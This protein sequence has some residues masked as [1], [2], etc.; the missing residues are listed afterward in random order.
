VVRSAE[1]IA[2]AVLLVALAGCA[3]TQ[4]RNARVKLQ[5]ERELA[6]RNPLR[7]GRLNPQVD[8]R[9]VALVRGHGES[10]VIVQLAS[11]SATPLTDVPIAVGVRTAHGRPVQLNG[12]PRLGWFSTHVAAIAPH[13]ET[14]WVFTTRRALPSGVRP[15]ARVGVPGNGPH[16]DVAKLPRLDVTALGGGR[17]R[18]RNASGVPQLDL[19]VY[20]V[21]RAGGRPVA[22]GRTSLAQLGGDHETTVRV[23]L[24]GRDSPAPPEAFSTPTIVG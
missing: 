10:A 17:V 13:S 23:P 3:T 8:V 12:A 24:V 18:V 21:A 16:S 20:A 19:P 14:S 5:A 6:A 22:A 15:F 4:Q 1:L 7:V 2:L 9:G 11:R